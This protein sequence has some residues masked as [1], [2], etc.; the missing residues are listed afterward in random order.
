MWERNRLGLGLG[1][2]MSKGLAR[3][4]VRFRNRHVLGV[5]LMFR[6]GLG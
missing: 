2:E 3:V 5:G 6:I 4:G 1:L